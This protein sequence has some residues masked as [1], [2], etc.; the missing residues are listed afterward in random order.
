MTK[1]E[2]RPQHVPIDSDE[3]DNN[4]QPEEPQNESKRVKV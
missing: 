4:V 3:A 1:I 2:V